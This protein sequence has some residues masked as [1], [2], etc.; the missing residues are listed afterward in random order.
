MLAP[1]PAAVAAAS[2][3]ALG[4]VFG[5][6]LGVGAVLFGGGYTLVALLEPHAVA[7][8]GWLTPGQYLD[9]I[10]LSQAVPGPISTLSAFVGYAAAGLPGA[11]LATSGVYLP[12]FVA[13]IVAARHVE[14]LRGA[15]WARAALDG[16][17]AVV[18]GSIFGVGLALLPAAVDGLWAG[19][20][21]MAALLAMARGRVPAAAVVLAGLGAGLVKLALT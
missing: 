20:L 15:E 18:T 21:F 7:G 3:S 17:N 14:R 10:A 5:L 11:V 8:N 4:K 1:I 16:V 19:L 2:A 6:H 9:G 12:A 13:V